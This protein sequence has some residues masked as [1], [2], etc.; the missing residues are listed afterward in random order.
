MTVSFCAVTSHYAG[1]TKLN[2]WEL[3]KQ[4]FLCPLCCLTNNIIVL[5]GT[6]V[7]NILD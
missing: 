1:F 2:F 4:D 7:H 6:V 3:L 5:L